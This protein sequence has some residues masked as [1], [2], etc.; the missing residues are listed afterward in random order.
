MNW[1]LSG[2]TNIAVQPSGGMIQWRESEE[3][4]QLLANPAIEKGLKT[5]GL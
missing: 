3:Q 2:L 4:P 1:R 5:S